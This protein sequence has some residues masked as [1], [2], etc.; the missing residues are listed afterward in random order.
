MSVAPPLRL[1]RL[2]A[3]CDSLSLPS[4]L[5]LRMILQ[6]AGGQVREVCVSL[7]LY[8]HRVK[9]TVAVQECQ[10]QPF[11]PVPRVKPNPVVAADEPR[12]YTGANVE[13]GIAIGA[14]KRCMSV[15]RL[16]NSALYWS[17][18]R[19]KDMD[20][21]LETLKMVEE[22]EGVRCSFQRAKEEVK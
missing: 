8:D 9:P 15:G 5:L 20:D 19:A 4:R 14:F 16:R 10:V 21:V 11:S 18:Y 12:Y 13:L 7:I 3:V 6:C 1:V 2:D 17:V 22:F